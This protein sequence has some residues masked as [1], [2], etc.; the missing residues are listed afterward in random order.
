MRREVKEEACAE[1]MDAKLLGFCRGECVRG[2]EKGLVLVRSFWLASVQLK[3]WEPEPETFARKLVR[4]DQVLSEQA[5]DEFAMIHHRVL[6][7][8]GML[9]GKRPGNDLVAQRCRP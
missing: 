6:I 1:V 4:P 9:K 8:A 3:K 2:H 5:P 7:V